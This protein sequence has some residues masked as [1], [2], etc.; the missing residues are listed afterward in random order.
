MGWG[1]AWGLGGAGAALPS[2]ETVAGGNT[3]GAAL[4]TPRSRRRGMV[5]I[6]LFHHPEM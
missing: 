6:D 2:G 4:H 5:A 3:T 1:M